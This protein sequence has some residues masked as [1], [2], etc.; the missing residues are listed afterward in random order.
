MQ[1]FVQSD[2]QKWVGCNDG[3]ITYG[4]EYWSTETVTKKMIHSKNVKFGKFHIFNVI[5]F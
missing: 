3:I 5:L 2:F 1:Y 4:Y